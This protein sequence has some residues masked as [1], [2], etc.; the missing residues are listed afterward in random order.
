MAGTMS[1]I[2]SRFKKDIKNSFQAQKNI[3]D[4]TEKYIG[5]LENAE[6]GGSGGG[7]TVT[8]IASYDGSGIGYAADAEVTVSDDISNY[9]FLMFTIKYSATEGLPNSILAVNDLKNVYT[10]RAYVFH[11]GG[12]GVGYTDVLYL[13]DTKIKVL[14]ASGVYI[15]DIY[16]IKI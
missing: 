1:E 9:D 6:G 3:I 7:I 12:G 4:V 13:S 10:T 16:G 15:H 5:L 8:K 11:D 2:L 14:R